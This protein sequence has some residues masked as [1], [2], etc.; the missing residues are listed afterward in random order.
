MKLVASALETEA[1]ETFSNLLNEIA[2]IFM[3][4]KLDNIMRTFSRLAWL[5]RENTRKIG[6]EVRDLL[7]SWVFAPS[8]WQCYSG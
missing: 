8:Y 4:N 3:R 1:R 6:L 2:D 5:T 7:A